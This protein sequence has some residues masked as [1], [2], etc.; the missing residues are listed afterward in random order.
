[1]KRLDFRL[2]IG[3]G[4][5]LL[6]ALMLLERAGIVRGLVNVLWGVVFLLGA[7]YFMHRFAV[8][9]HGSWWAAIP[10]FA[11]A[12]LAAEDL[13]PAALG[14]WHGLLFLGTLGAG[15]FA[16]Y[17]SGRQ[18]WWAIIPG[19]VLITLGVI[20]VLADRFGAPETGAFLFVGLGV[21]FLLVAILSRM[22][23]AY[24]PATALLALGA[25][26]GTTYGSAF[27]LLWP[28]ALILA[29]LIVILRFA[30]HQ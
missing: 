21:T 19:G 12:G 22:R 10:A 26:L 2:L 3:V 27:G 5:V 13:V 14:N 15:F 28:A 18:R 11:L 29:G 6:G 9:M 30:R 25:L 17:V 24:I 20:A 4:L 7:A 1:M 8:D 23:W 16:V